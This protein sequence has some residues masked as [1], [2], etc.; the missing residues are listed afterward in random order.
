MPRLK[1]T[2]PVWASTLLARTRPAHILTPT[3]PL[4]MCHDQGTAAKY[5]VPWA[6]AAP[7]RTLQSPCKGWVPSIC[8]PNYVSSA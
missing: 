8:N 3:S 1:L 7:A 5:Y 4:V 2:K 6:A